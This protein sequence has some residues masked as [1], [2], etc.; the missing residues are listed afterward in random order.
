MTIMILYIGRFF[1][2]HSHIRTYIDGSSMKRW[3]KS[4][5]VAE[6]NGW[7]RENV[8]DMWLWE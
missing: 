3:W 8:D 1:H 6:K 7:S 4:V 5:E 2:T